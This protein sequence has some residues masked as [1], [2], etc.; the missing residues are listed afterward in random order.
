[1][2]WVLVIHAIQTFANSEET[3]SHCL[4]LKGAAFPVEVRNVLDR[5]D[6]LVCRAQESSRM[7]EKSRAAARRR[8]RSPGQAELALI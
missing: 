3:C 5:H 2:L 7:A 8:Q 4:S 1:M 6:R